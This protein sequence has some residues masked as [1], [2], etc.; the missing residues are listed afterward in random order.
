[1]KGQSG[2]PNGRP[3]NGKALTNLLAKRG[4]L[5]GQDGRRNDEALVELVWT[6]ALKGER[7]AIEM[8]WNRLE[9]KPVQPIEHSGDEDAPVRIVV[10]PSGH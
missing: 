8:I 7:W 4:E 6:E 10:G 3:P 9:G 5:T 1:M 2:N